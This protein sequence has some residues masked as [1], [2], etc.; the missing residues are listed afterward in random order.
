MFNRAAHAVNQISQFRLTSACRA[1]GWLLAPSSC[2]LCDA[3]GLAVD[4][5]LCSHCAAALPDSQQAL[6]AGT[7]P[8]ECVYCPWNYEYPVDQLIRAFKFHGDRTG[9]R[10]LGTLMARSRSALAP[11]LPDLLVPVPLHPR[12][13]RERGYNQAAEIARFAARECKIGCAPHQLQRVRYTAEQSRLP[14]RERQRN[15]KNAFTCTRSIAGLRIALV[16]DVIT[17]GS[18]ALAAAD[19]LAMAGAASIEL[20][21]LATALIRANGAGQSRRRRQ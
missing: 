16:D 10:V 6:R 2:L 17:T 3:P 1:L 4:I 20:W 7:T 12:R 18:T 14:G 15:L 5:D 9:A 8:I 13:L 11:P 19:A 21:V